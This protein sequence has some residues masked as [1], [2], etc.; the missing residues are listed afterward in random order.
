MVDAVLFEFL[1]TEMVAELWAHEP[2]PDPSPGVSTRLWVG[3]E[4][5]RVVAGRRDLGHR[6]H[7]ERGSG[8]DRTPAPPLP[9]WK[10][11]G[12]GFLFCNVGGGASW[13]GIAGY[14]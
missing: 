11:W 6:E 8:R 1:H 3:E 10:T 7:R 4:E 14:F 13:A 9:R 5:A 2:D 12:A